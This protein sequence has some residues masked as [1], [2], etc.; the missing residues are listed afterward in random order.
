MGGRG[1]SQRHPCNCQPSPRNLACGCQH[2]RPTE[3]LRLTSPDQPFACCCCVSQS[4]RKNRSGQ[5]AG[6]TGRQQR[7]GGMSKSAG[8][9]QPAQ[10]SPDPRGLFQCK[11]NGQGPQKLIEDSVSLRRFQKKIP[12]NP[13]WVGEVPRLRQVVRL[14]DIGHS[15]S[16]C[17]GKECG[18]ADYF[19]PRV[20]PSPS[21]RRSWWRGHIRAITFNR[22]PPHL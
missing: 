15:P 16:T 7:L 9:C 5:Q 2:H 18:D 1:R 14:V 6:R 17:G 4:Q 3:N 19:S 13:C 12:G 21:G 22:T 8:Q 20:R 10:P 11:C